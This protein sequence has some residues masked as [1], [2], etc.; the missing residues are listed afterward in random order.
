[1]TTFPGFRLDGKTAI[2]TGASSGIGAAIAEAM[3]QAGANV[4]L[5]GRDEARL[6]ESRQ[7][8]GPDAV[9]AR[10]RHHAPTERRR[11]S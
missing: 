10:A 5:V 6:G 1:M 4:V 8:C 7:L 9:D 11:M 2:V 3:A